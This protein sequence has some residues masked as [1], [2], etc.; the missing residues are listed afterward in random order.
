MGGGPGCCV[1]EAR[2][3]CAAGIGDVAAARSDVE[4][5][6][7][8]KDAMIAANVGY[9]PLQT[10][11]QVKTVMELAC[12]AE[13]AGNKE[14]ARDC[15]AK[16]QKLTARRDSDRAPAGLHPRFVDNTLVAQ[17]NTSE[18]AVGILEI[19]LDL[20]ARRGAPAS[21]LGEPI[22]KAAG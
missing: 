5:L 10:D 8:L 13:A 4:R 22:F 18:L 2:E 1:I 14:A 7:P 11:F 3:L 15:Y 20:T 19:K 17:M 9:W 21:N 12:A 6:Q 16:L